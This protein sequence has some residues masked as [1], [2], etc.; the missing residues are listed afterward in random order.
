MCQ[1]HFKKICAFA[2]CIIMATPH[3]PIF[4]SSNLPPSYPSRFLFRYIYPSL[5]GIL[6]NLPV[7]LYRLL[8]SVNFFQA[9]ISLIKLSWNFNCYFMIPYTSVFF[10]LCSLRFLR[11]WY[12]WFILLSAF[13]SHT[14]S[15][16]AQFFSLSVRILS[17][18]LC[19]ISEVI[20]YTYFLWN[21]NTF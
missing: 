8:V 17:I 7:C 3:F 6:F 15:L 16:L 19:F 18:I 12:F 1:S 14:A 10:V 20:L 5:L 4:F 9:L 2:T 13:F 21:L 11:W